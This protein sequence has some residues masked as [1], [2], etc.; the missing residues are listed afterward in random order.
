VTADTIVVMG[1]SFGDKLGSGG[2][3]NVYEATREDDEG[4]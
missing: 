2:F 3:G 4:R 1:W